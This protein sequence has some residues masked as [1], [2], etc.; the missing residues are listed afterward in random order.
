MILLLFDPVPG[1]GLC[2]RIFGPH[3]IVKLKLIAKTYR[4][5]RERIE[6]N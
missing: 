5:L 1:K 4:K 3:A 2:S 6:S